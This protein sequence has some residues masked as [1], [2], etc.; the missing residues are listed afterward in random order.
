[1]EVMGVGSAILP[2][3]CATSE[4]HRPN[5]LQVCELRKMRIISQPNLIWRNKSSSR[6]FFRELSQYIRT[7]M[8]T[9]LSDVVSVIDQ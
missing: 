7:I 9:K 4:I 5:E 3:L 2:R 6:V 8:K 1:M